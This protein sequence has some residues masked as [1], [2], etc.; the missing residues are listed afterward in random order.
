MAEPSPRRKR[1]RRIFVVLAV[2]LALVPVA[3]FVALRSSGFRQSVL[4]QIAGW[5][6]TEYGL[7]L[8]ARDFDVRWDGFALDGVEVGA[9]E[10][11]PV[12]RASRVDVSMDMGTLRGPVRVIRNLEI[13]DP[14]L[15][16]S[17]PIPK[18][19]ESDPQAPPGF[20][21][22]RMV[23]RRGSVLGPPPEPPLSDW[24]RSWRLDEVE[25]G[26]SYVAGTWEVSIESSRAR[27]E[28]PSFPLLELQLGTHVTSREGEP[29]SIEWVRATGD[30]LRLTGSGSVAMEG[31]SSRATFD[32]QVEPRLLAAGAPPGGSVRAK[33][34]LWLPD[35]VQGQVAVTARSV[36]AE[37]LRPYV[38]AGLFQDLSLAGTVA[39]AEADLQLSPG[40][41]GKGKVSWR[42]GDRQLVR[43]DLGVK[44]EQAVRLT[45]AGDLLP[46]S[47][48]R[49]HVRGTVTASSWAELAKG[50]AERIDAEVRLPDLSQA[51]A[52]V[53]AIWPRLIA[54]MPEGVPVQGTLEADARLSGVLTSPSAKVDALW[55]PEPGARVKVRAEGRVATWTG[56]ARAEMENLPIALLGL[57]PDVG[58]GLVPSRAGEAAQATAAAESGASLPPGRGQAPPL[59]PE[60]EA[61]R[62]SGT[63]E[64]SGSPRSYRTTVDAE[65]TQAAYRPYLES[66]ERGRI[67]GKGSLALRPLTYTGTLDLD[68]TG[69]F[70]RPNASSTAR[71]AS[72]QI[73]SDG[74]LKLEP[75]TYAGRLTFSGEGLD[76]P[77]MALAEQLN[78][79][80]DG[81]FRLDPLSYTG[82][83][84][85]DGTRVGVP[86]TVR[87][88]RVALGADGTL[89]AKMPAGNAR[90]DASGVEILAA[91]ATLVDLH[92]EAS[93]DGKQVR[94]ASLT[95]SLPEGQTFAASGGFTVDL[96]TADLDLRL[97]RPVDPVREA[98]LTATL[99]QGVVELSA[100]RIDTDAGPASLRATV[101]L[102]A[103]AQIPELAKALA[104][105]PIEPAPGEIS[106]HAQAPEVD[107]ESLL[108]ALG[109]EARPER[110]RAGVT[111]DLTFDPAA[112]AAGRGEILVERLSLETKD[113][114]VAA[115][116]PVIARLER[117]RLELQPVRLRVE[118]A[119]IGATAVDVKGT[120][121]L[122][123][124]WKP[125]QDLKALVRSLSAEAGGT[126]DAALL[127][128]FLEGGIASGALT[129][130]GSAS[131]T[132]DR[133]EAT[134]AANGPEASFW[135]PAAAARIEGPAVIGSWS[136]ETWKASGSAGLN[137]G[138]LAFHARPEEDAALVSLNLEDVPYRLDYGLT[139]RVD[140]VLSL[141]IP[142]PLTDEARLRL[143]GTLDVERGLLV[144][145]INLDREVLT[146]LLAPE[147]TPGTEE[148]LAS[149][150][151][152]DLAV[153]TEDGIRVRNNVADLRAHWTSLQVGGTAEV[154][155]IRGRVE[156]DPGGRAELYGQTVRI[157]RGSLIFTGNPAQDPLVDMATTSSLEDPSIVRLAGRPLDVQPE[158]EVALEKDQDRNQRGTQASDILTSGLAGY[159]G[160]R[161]VSRLGESIGLSRLSVRPVLFDETD[162]TARLAIGRDLSPNAS[163]AVSVDLRAPESRIWLLDLHGFRGLPGFTF[164]AFTT[165]DSVEGGSLQ[166]TLNL[167][168]TREVREESDRLRRLRLDLPPGTSRWT[169]QSLRRAVGLSRKDPVP[170]EAPFETEVDLA[171]HLRRS[172]Y[173]G[174]LVT[175]EA[176]P[177]EG[178]HGWVDLNVK[179]VTLGPRVDFT[180]SGDKPPR[181]FRP[182]ILA[183]YRPDFYEER[184]L[185]EMKETAVRAFRSAGHLD[186]AVEIE[187]RREAGD[188]PDGPRT[189][190]IRS[191]AGPREKLEEL[192]IAGLDPD[193]GRLAAGS[194]PGRLSRAELAAAVP[195]ADRRLLGA[196]RSLGYPQAK[197]AGREVAGPRLTVRVEPGPRQVFGDVAITGVEGEERERL[198]ALVQARSGDGFRADLVSAGVLRLEDSLRSR[199]YP[200]AAVRAVIR[201]DDV[202]DVRYEIEPGP[203]VRL[204]EVEFE[205][206]RW[207][208][209]G[210]LARVTGLEPGEPLDRN[211]VTEAQGRLY[212]TGAFSRV[213]AAVDRP[214]EGEARVTFSVAESPRFHL[215]YGVRWESGAGTKAILDLSDTNFLRRGLILGFRGLYEPD[216]RSGRVFLRTGGLFGTG[217][218]L[219]VFGSARRERL[220]DEI[221]G[222]LRRDTDES[223]LQFARPFGRRTTG[224]LYFRYRTVHFFEV[225]PDPF[226]PFDLELSRPYMGTQFLHDS[227]D[228][229]LDP[230]AG[231]FRSVDLSGSGPFLGSDF[232]YARLYGQVHGYRTF[233]VA[234]RPVVWAQAVQTGVAQAWSGQSL[235]S[236]DRFFAGGEFS[237]RGY[238]KRTLRVEEG[239]PREE[240]LLV[241][242]QELRFPLFL[243]DLKGL[244]FFDAGQVWEGLGAFDT[245][246]AK[247]LGFGFR[248]KSP[249]GL[250]RL[251][252][253]FP[254]DRRPGDESYQLY[255]GLGNAF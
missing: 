3:V 39:D 69:L 59:H 123:P 219:E 147:D 55:V 12:F 214:E 225:E 167:G 220:P 102:G 113:G 36:P 43:M 132:P 108:E 170:R 227:R 46:G 9:P 129:F 97:I 230:T 254:L 159:Y 208:S 135:W 154:P 96:Q 248:M 29:V 11:K 124:A 91:G 31:A 199:G 155:A 151:D 95:G 144:R 49:R 179:V 125:A 192:E 32:V 168:G 53:R 42:R 232:N 107:S 161:V 156:I 240:T 38:D 250:L 137:G 98:E 200:D 131:G 177:V 35:P 1:L 189:V 66:L 77:G 10:A 73:A 63:I 188:A 134:L 207:T 89:A 128:P 221:L 152:L 6:R 224:R 194:F 50:T 142:L 172:G 80:S 234:G 26:G 112:P 60:A 54:A 218:S 253:A 222:D 169:R 24:V 205:G 23:F 88:E 185:A 94:I 236:D 143:D 229:R 190:V 58:E 2:L 228:D 238:E 114:T 7:V 244:V 231:V 8:K 61:G 13:D 160:A 217:I 14:V 180:F 86:D 34:E 52:E 70:A 211:A 17:A 247:S 110:L 215:G 178:R 153:T 93:G 158:A 213:T 30:G 99:R 62:L 116:A 249:V 67:S 103:L 136:G 212:R 251:D 56:S 25:G 64:L 146:L 193:L 241:L 4:R 246:L 111:A 51:V 226:F 138:T 72:F 104:A 196:L 145:D 18:L 37:V 176:V 157:D 27:V 15:D 210:Q 204:A 175:A 16:L 216:D 203:S 191:A 45:A 74:T 20:S 198:A 148:T 239:D 115:E 122:D 90:L 255:L 235:I 197:I 187:V 100:P 92:A 121:D 83:I 139:T 120:A 28:R 201:G 243:E 21:I 57:S 40:V 223:S 106:I 118:S 81:I 33:G 75:V 209:P 165:E 68:G 182:E 126:L 206:E 5:L 163:F 181:A 140:G 242:N 174:A 233:R 84:S 41:E 186:P 149:R 183:A 202:V 48:G 171:E 150:I 47:P 79:E 166:Q 78:V 85:L 164:E 141:R 76:A 19:P 237:V 252:L 22:T 127:N 184:S 44:E 245:D 101:P 133:L 105:L 119:E 82:K 109:M 162:P 71:L 173:P 117:G 130:S 65:V 87:A 195:G